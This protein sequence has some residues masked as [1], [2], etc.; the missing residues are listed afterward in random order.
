M[1]LIERPQGIVIRCLL[2]RE[3]A[4]A[5]HLAAGGFQFAGGAHAVHEAPETDREQDSGV[6]ARRAPLLADQTD[7]ELRPVGVVEGIQV[8]SHK[9]DGMIRREEGIERG[10]QLPARLPLAG[11]LRHRVGLLLL[12][13]TPTS[14]TG[15][16]G[17]SALAGLVQLL[18][19]VHRAPRTPGGSPL[20]A[21]P[22]GALP[23]TVIPS[24]DRTPHVT[25][26]GAAMRHRGLMEQVS[27]PIRSHPKESE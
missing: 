21:T 16:S 9:A 12:H 20:G 15:S 3:P 25:Q 4:V 11:T 14:E 10:R 13:S 27:H 18:C 22:Y 7:P 5:Q 24:T 8:G 23:G 2:A 19:L 26:C 1:G 6:V 17:R